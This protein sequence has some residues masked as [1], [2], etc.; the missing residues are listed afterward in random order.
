MTCSQIFLIC[1]VLNVLN[2]VV[3]SQSQVVEKLKN[4]KKTEVE[5]S[6]CVTLET[7]SVLVIKTCTQYSIL[8]I[9]SI[10]KCLSFQKKIVSHLQF[11]TSKERA[12]ESCFSL[13]RRVAQKSKVSPLKNKER[14]IQHLERTHLAKERLEMDPGKFRFLR[15]LLNHN[16]NQASC[17]TRVCAKY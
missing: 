5:K 2:I 11:S 16:S 12:I 7:Q 15:A 6:N 9:F 10:L 13:A 14:E 8:G 1:K 4:Q 3:S 17:E